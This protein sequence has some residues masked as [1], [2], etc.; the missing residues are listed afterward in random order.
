MSVQ[1]NVQCTK[2]KAS[3]S[4]DCIYLVAGDFIRIFMTGLL[5]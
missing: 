1:L 4:E 5:S 2:Q 3:I